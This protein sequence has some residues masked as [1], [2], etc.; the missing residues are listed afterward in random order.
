MNPQPKNKPKRNPKFLQF[1]RNQTCLMC[2][3]NMAEAHHV[4]RLKWMAGVGQR[5]HD[6]CTLPL[7]QVNECHKPETEKWLDCEK[8]IANYMT[9][10]YIQEYGID[11]LIEDLMELLE[12]K[13]G[14]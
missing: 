5:P 14:K 6:Y 13:R 4:R 12:S 7:C 11:S 9:M 8:L 1:I 3:N 10:Y 2:N